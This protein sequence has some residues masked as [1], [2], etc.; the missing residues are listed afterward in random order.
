MSSAQLR[1]R[2]QR[3]VDEVRAAGGRGTPNFWSNGRHVIGARSFEGLEALI[4]AELGG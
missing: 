1:E 4:D 2:V 3:D